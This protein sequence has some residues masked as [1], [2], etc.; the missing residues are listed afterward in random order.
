MAT[1]YGG[2]FLQ[3]MASGMQSGFEMGWKKK[4]QKKLEAERAKIIDESAIFNNTIKQ[5]G[6]DNLYSEDEISMIN[7]AWLI[8]GAEAQERTKGTRDAIQAMDKGKVEQDFQWLE[9]VSGW[10][11]G[12]DPTNAKGILDYASQ[13]ITTKKAKD[14]LTAYEK[15][16]KA[17]YEAAQKPQTVSPYDF[18]GKSPA[19]VQGQ[20]AGSV[21]GQT[22]GLE[23]VKFKPPATTPQ[24]PKISDHISAVNYLSK[25]VNATPE[26]FNKIKAGLQNQFPDLDLSNITQEALRKSPLIAEEDLANTK[27]GDDQYYQEME[28]T[29][30]PTLLQKG[31]IAVKNW[32]GME[33]N[34]GVSPTGNVAASAANLPE[35]K[36]GVLYTP[37]I[38]EQVEQDKKY[39]EQHPDSIA[40]IQKALK[41]KGYW[42]YAITGEWSTNLE[43]ALRELYRDQQT[44]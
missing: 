28:E 21:A 24:A 29:P 19:E 34:Q 27:E 4:Q 41:E 1:G 14:L 11:E 10:T 9:L 37:E 5:Y 26:I 22:P 18:Y 17:K 12:L 3:G 35:A 44:Q 30:K 36:T 38:N 43:K 23:G 42:D 15:M 32:L 8:M 31:V 25:F 7:T 6:A 2:Y 39:T 13:N 16:H 33:R 20:I 40:A